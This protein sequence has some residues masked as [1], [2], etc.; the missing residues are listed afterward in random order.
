MRSGGGH[1]TL[2]YVHGANL[3]LLPRARGP[4][5]CYSSTFRGVMSTST[6]GHRL[7]RKAFHLG[8]E[9]LQTPL[10]CAV[11]KAHLEEGKDIGDIDVLSDIAAS[12]GMMT[13]DE[14]CQE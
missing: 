7:S 12:V 13:K 14:V 2:S 10:L 8:G 6:R 9:H 3:L 5:L 4:V 11:F 1:S